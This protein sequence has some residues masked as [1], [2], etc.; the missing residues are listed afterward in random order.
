MCLLASGSRSYLLYD[1]RV[2]VSVGDYPVHGVVL[3]YLPIVEQPDHLKR[4]GACNNAEFTVKSLDTLTSKIPSAKSAFGGL[5]LVTGSWASLFHL[6]H[7]ISV[8][9]C[10]K[11]QKREIF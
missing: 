11:C 6:K 2:D 4:L 9:F 7:I 5:L 10:K 1:K 8:F 3:P